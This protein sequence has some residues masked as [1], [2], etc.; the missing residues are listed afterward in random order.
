MVDIKSVADV[1]EG[2]N[3][4]T[5]DEETPPIVPVSPP[6]AVPTQSDIFTH[7]FSLPFNLHQASNSE[8]VE[9][10]DGRWKV[11]SITDTSHYFPIYIKVT[12]TVIRYSKN[13]AVSMEFLNDDPTLNKKKSFEYT[14]TNEKHDLGYKSWFL[15]SE[16]TEEAGFLHDGCLKVRVTIEPV[17]ILSQ[18]EKNGMVGLRNQGATCYLNSLIQTL[19]HTTLFR[20]SVYHMP[21]EEATESDGDYD[22]S[23]SSSSYGTGYGWRYNQRQK[24][25]AKLQLAEA[26]QRLFY[27]LQTSSSSV[28]TRELTRS[29]GWSDA[30]SFEQHDA[31]EMNRVMLDKLME[32]LST[33]PYRGSINL[34]LEGRM[35][36]YIKC[37]HVDFES[38]RE[39]RFFDLNLPVRGC[40]TL[41]DSLRKYTEDELLDGD[42]QYSA[43]KFGYQDAIRST[44]FLELPPVLHL[45]LNR[46]E[47]DMNTGR[48]AKLNDRF[49]FPEQ[50]DMSPF[51]INLDEQQ[52]RKLKERRVEEQEA[53]QKRKMEKLQKEGK[54]DVHTDIPMAEDMQEEFQPIIESK[55]RHSLDSYARYEPDEATYSLHSVLVHSGYVGGGHYYAYIRPDCAGQWYCLNDTT[56]TKVDSSEAIESTFG[57]S[58][59]AGYSTGYR[60]RG[61]SSANAYML[62]YVR[63]DVKDVVLKEV[64]MESIPAHIQ[65]GLNA[66]K[67]KKSRITF[68]VYTNTT[69]DK[70]RG[71]LQ[72]AAEEEEKKLKDAID[73][74]PT[75]KQCC[76]DKRQPF[77]STQAMSFSLSRTATFKDLYEELEKKTHIPRSQQRIWRLANVKTGEKAS[78]GWDDKTEYRPTQ[79]LDQMTGETD[80]NLVTSVFSTFM[81]PLFIEESPA[82]DVEDVPNDEQLLFVKH[83]SQ[84]APDAPFGSIFGASLLFLGPIKLRPDAT[85]ASASGMIQQLAV[86]D[87]IK[88]WRAEHSDAEVEEE[89]TRKQAELASLSTV[90]YQYVQDSVG[91]LLDPSLTV[92]EHFLSPGSTIIT[93][94]VSPSFAES[95]LSGTATVE[96]RESLCA[97]DVEEKRLRTAVITLQNADPKQEP[98]T[99]YME[100]DREMPQREFM[101]L[102]STKLNHPINQILLRRKE[103]Y[104]TDLTTELLRLHLDSDS[105]NNSANIDSSSL[106]DL[107]NRYGTTYTDKRWRYHSN[108]PLIFTL[109]DEPLSEYVTKEHI[110]VQVRDAYRPLQERVI[111]RES[112]WLG[113]VAEEGHDPL[114]VALIGGS[115]MASY[116]LSFARDASVGDVIQLLRTKM[117]TE[118]PEALYAKS[119]ADRL[120]SEAQ[121]ERKIIE[122][123]TR[124]LNLKRKGELYE[125]YSSDEGYSHRKETAWTKRSLRILMDAEENPAVKKPEKDEPDP[126]NDEED[127]PP[128]YITIPYNASKD[129][130]EILINRI[131]CKALDQ[132]EHALPP[133]TADEPFR[134]D[135]SS[136]DYSS[137]PIRALLLPPSYTSEKTT[138]LEDDTAVTEVASDKRLLV[139]EFVPPPLSWPVDESTVHYIP[140]YFTSGVRY[141]VEWISITQKKNTFLVPFHKG[142]RK[143]TL[144]RRIY[145]VVH[146]I[147]SDSQFQE[148]EISFFGEKSAEIPLKTTPDTTAEDQAA[149]FDDL[150]FIILTA[151]NVRSRPYKPFSYNTSWR[152]KE[153][154]I[155]IKD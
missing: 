109:I 136:L 38:A 106:N 152:R 143:I 83:Y 9:V 108:N 147:M 76:I 85:L 120:Q 96:E 121:K 5:Q 100:C 91:P 127:T 41:E 144:L 69:F 24:K 140:V 33:T 105:E 153:T 56:V 14:F 11:F 22:S 88:S 98:Q 95:L 94:F 34:I 49:E 4:P 113:E 25:V 27:N 18:R 72:K 23:S 68:K 21:L 2:E 112:E 48:M 37:V 133:Q 123:R 137:V 46:W 16:C 97:F 118:R 101:Q 12:P 124:R 92:E 75:V 52:R 65:D 13:V 40:A 145:D 64:K 74:T 7:D 47:Y 148:T 62:V 45:Q 77:D 154:A 44:K 81:I 26:L 139:V 114:R 73:K 32:K 53:L 1:Q 58:E 149:L 78:N 10:F 61:T 42:N 66:Q 151:A 28:S 8:E 104:N 155:V 110:T 111:V 134:T 117:G 70:K 67:E 29:F 119:V 103:Y 50:L 102:L 122:R 90:F 36:S 17:K 80:Q 107:V 31:S 129:E 51:L 71:Y 125:D 6:S 128:E 89:R 59:P 35:Y 19:F 116:P 87:H 79:L 146:G 130:R 57:S 84:I 60:W 63:N 132:D 20:W 30:D 15:N 126:A 54:T 115:S 99:L 3:V 131:L 141:Y 150:S 86:Q 39:E 138:I 55:E 43:E 135:Y 82:A 93:Q 142:D